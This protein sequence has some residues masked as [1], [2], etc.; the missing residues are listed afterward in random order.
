[1]GRHEIDNQIVERIIKLP[2]S[3]TVIRGTTPVISFGDFTSSSLATLSINP[4]SR[5]FL[6]GSKLIKTGK[7]RLV[8]K[9]SL[10]IGL[11]EPLREEHAEAIWQG[12]RNYFGAHANPLDWF[13]DLN[14][15]LSHISR[16]YDDRDT[17]HVDLVQSATFPAWRGL[18]QKDQQHLIDEDFD[19]FKY[20]TSM[21]N[22]EVL[23]V[24]GRQ[25]LEQLKITPGFNVET[26]DVMFF[27]VADKKVPTSLFKGTG[28]NGKLVLGWTGT[29][30]SLHISAPVRADLY[31]R[32]GEWLKQEIGK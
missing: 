32:L 3:P 2:T 28:P 9:E 14:E 12:C 15:V 11:G 1:M 5:E 7:K 27:D 13:D 24:N 30:K 6:Q 26:V 16:K 18:T 23:L 19:F 31:S 4:S 20:Q 17:C 21:P 25:V 29:L 10:G 22:L 8:D